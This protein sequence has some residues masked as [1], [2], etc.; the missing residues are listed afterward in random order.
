MEAFNLWGDSIRKMKVLVDEAGN[1][2]LFQRE[3]V[4][5][6]VVASWRIPGKWKLREVLHIL[7]GRG[8]LVQLIPFHSKSLRCEMFAAVELNILEYV[9]GAEEM[10]G[11]WK[12]LSDGIDESLL[13]IHEKDWG[14]NLVK[15]DDEL[16]EGPNAIGFFLGRHEA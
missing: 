15:G 13:V 7:G 8:G 14:G 3:D 10:G 11:V 16:F 1:K 12:N 9:P 6:E 5:D 2:F 4:L